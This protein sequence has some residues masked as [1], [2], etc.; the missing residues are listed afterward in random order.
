MIKL[1]DVLIVLCLLGLSTGLYFLNN[2]GEGSIV[3]IDYNGYR[4]AEVDYTE[5]KDDE[6]LTYYLNGTII[7]VDKDGAY[8]KES[9]CSGQVCVESGKVNKVGQTVVCLPNRVSIRIEGNDAEFDGIT[10]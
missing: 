6:V 10:G 2:K 1:R 4:Y 3:Q 9:T 8:F 5:L 7:I